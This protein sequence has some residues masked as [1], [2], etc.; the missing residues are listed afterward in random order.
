L[1]GTAQLFIPIIPHAQEAK[2]RRIIVGDQ[3]RQKVSKI[4]SQSS[5]LGVVAHAYDSSYMLCWEAK[6]RRIIV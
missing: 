4:P 2:I 1:T 3:P 6:G 5:K